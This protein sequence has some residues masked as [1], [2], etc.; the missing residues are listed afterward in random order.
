MDR[1]H[2][3]PPEGPR[4]G[5]PLLRPAVPPRGGIPALRASAERPLG[6]FSPAARHPQ[7]P[8][9]Q[10]AAPEEQAEEPIAAAAPIEELPWAVLDAPLWDEGQTEHATEAP[11]DAHNAAA[12]PGFGYESEDLTLDDEADWLDRE[13]AAQVPMAEDALEPLADAAEPGQEPLLGEELLAPPEWEY[14]FEEAVPSESLATDAAPEDVAPPAESP[15]QAQVPVSHGLE[16]VAARL[17]Q[18]ARSLRGRSPADLLSGASDPLQVLIAGYALGL[19][20]ARATHDAPHDE[21]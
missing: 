12:L 8:A 7:R 18:I 19:E 4:S 20:A 3:D 21:Q 5:S 6:P 17:E 10:A 13:S 2:T 11:A 1:P 16:E 9:A 14:G 15:A